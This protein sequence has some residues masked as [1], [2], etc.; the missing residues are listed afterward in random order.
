MAAH[1]VR[2]P[3]S[4]VLA[5]LFGMAGLAGCGGS[6]APPASSQ[7]SAPVQSPAGPSQPPASAEPVVAG[8]SCAKD[9]PGGQPVR[10]GLDGAT[11]LG[12]V[13][14]GN[15]KTAV[16]LAHE[17][18]KTLCMWASYAMELTRSG[19]RVLAIDLP[20]SASSQAA[21]GVSLDD[22]VIAGVAL[23]R[24]QGAQRVLLVGAS[25]GGTAVVAA[26]VKIAPPVAGVVSLSGPERFNDLDAV[27]AA[28][29]LAV[30]ALYAACRSDGDFAT[31]AE[32][33]HAATP[34]RLGAGLV[35]EE[36]ID[37]GGAMLDLAKIKTAVTRFLTAHAR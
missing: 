11:N 21:R 37:H 23:L 1:R 36:C 19:Y 9:M 22:A 13:V 20:G 27:G 2:L 26:A 10:F 25:M 30:P 6:A 3:L 28:P 8:A 14:V 32:R 29:R 17:R 24:G 18:R 12:G 35:I 34:A 33:L 5:G 31:S 4:I 16:L 7:S 15:G